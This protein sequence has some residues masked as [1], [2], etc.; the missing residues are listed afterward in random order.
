MTF[1]KRFAIAIVAII[2][3]FG[4]ASAQFRAGIKVG[5]DINKMSISKEA[6][7]D[8]N[9]RTGFTAGV[10]AEF[11]VPLVGIGMDAS[12]MYVHRLGEAVVD[13]NGTATEAKFKNDYLSIPLNL[14]YKVGLPGLGSILT[15]YFFTGPQFSFLL[16]KK[17]VN[18]FIKNKSCDISWNVG[19]GLQLVKH[20]Q[21]A[22]S[23]GF[24]IN[25]AA[26]YIPL[27]PNSNGKNVR[28]SGWTVTAAYLF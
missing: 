7:T 1:N 17:D 6:V 8:K 11:T 9:N 25:H 20:L 24:G 19:V 21:V 26:K 5:M 10:M 14:K 18:Q 22:A 28:N 16:S 27:L 4:T 3:L 13:D 12:L 23:Y 15:P 2:A